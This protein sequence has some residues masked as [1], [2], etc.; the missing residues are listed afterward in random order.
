MI[1]VYCRQ[2]QRHQQNWQR[3]WPITTVVASFFE[4]FE[5]S[6]TRVFQPGSMLASVVTLTAPCCFP[7]VLFMSEN[8]LV[9]LFSLVVTVWSCRLVVTSSF[10]LLFL[11]LLSIWGYVLVVQATVIVTTIVTTT[12]AKPSRT[13]KRHSGNRSVVTWFT[14]IWKTNILNYFTSFQLYFVL[15]DAMSTKDTKPR[16]ETVLNERT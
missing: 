11:L 5:F 15:Y 14:F 9:K 4:L 16:T 10:L 13:K 7:I 2:Q 1:S 12:V 6:F 3:K 8:F